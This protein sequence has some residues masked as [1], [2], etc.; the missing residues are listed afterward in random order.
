[1]LTTGNIA[2]LKMDGFLPSLNWDLFK[3]FCIKAITCMII[4]YALME[5]SHQL[6]SL[7]TALT[8]GVSVANMDA[9]AMYA[10]MKTATRSTAQMA[11]NKF[12][13]WKAKRQADKEAAGAKR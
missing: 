9:K 2:F 1:M 5:M 11:Q 12:K 10:T 7:T 4:L 8:G 6:T 3:L 13:E